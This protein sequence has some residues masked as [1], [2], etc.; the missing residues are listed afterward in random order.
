MMQ[1]LGFTSFTMD[2]CPS[3]SRICFF[4]VRVSWGDKCPERLAAVKGVAG[5][6]GRKAESGSMGFTPD[7]SPVLEGK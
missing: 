7:Y 1:R 3:G 6:G 5:L 4:G 2:N